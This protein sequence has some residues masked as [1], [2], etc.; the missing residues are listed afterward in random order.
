MGLF[1]GIGVAVLALAGVGGYVVYDS[2][3]KA[4]EDRIRYAQEVKEKAE[5]ARIASERAKQ[6]EADA[7]S[8]PTALSITS[9]PAGA[10]VIATWKG[11]GMTKTTN[12][13]LEVAKMTAV[14]LVFKKSGFLDW[15]T[16]AVADQN[17]TI[18][19]RLTIDPS[20][21]VAQ[22]KVVEKKHERKPR[23]DSGSSLDSNPDATLTVDFGDDIDPDKEKK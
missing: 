16:D 1:I 3:K 12:F 13:T 9:D 2:N 4:E 17:K 18:T 21:Q 14:H 19:A 22:A 5:Q 23:K 7:A 11:G 6:V 15:E 20:R 10:E 8:A